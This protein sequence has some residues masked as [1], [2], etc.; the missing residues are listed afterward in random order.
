MDKIAI[1]KSIGLIGKASAKLT[2]DVQTVAIACACHALAH[3]DVTLADQLVDAL[4]KAMRRASLRAWFELHTPMYLPK[5]KTVFALDKDRAKAMRQDEG[6]AEALQSKPW[7][8]ALKEAPAI[9]VL[10]VA[11]AFDKFMKRIESQVKDA[12]CTVKNRA[13]LEELASSNAKYH[14]A[15]DSKSRI[16]LAAE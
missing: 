15:L 4:G 6:F 11:D 13:L 9:T 3:G 1:L 8:E 10:D 7:E 14:A 16:S 5:G 2:K 12:A